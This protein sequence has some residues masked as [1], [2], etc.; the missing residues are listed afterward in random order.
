MTQSFQMS[1]KQSRPPPL[2]APFTRCTFAFSSTSALSRCNPRVL[3]IG[4]REWPPIKYS[5][6]GLW[7]L[8]RQ[9][10]FVPFL[11][12]LGCL[13]A[14]RKKESVHFTLTEEYCIALSPHTTNCSKVY[15]A[16]DRRYWLYPA[17]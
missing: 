14:G 16:V 13:L 1:L 11:I 6:S 8:S 2:P 5:S 9:V 17:S 10:V 4:C 12:G 7:S 3:P 15:T